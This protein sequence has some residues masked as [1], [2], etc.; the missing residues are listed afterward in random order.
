MSLSLLI[1]LKKSLMKA[2][3]TCDHCD[4]FFCHNSLFMGRVYLFMWI[5]ENIILKFN[6]E[7]KISAVSLVC[8][9]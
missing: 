4:E 2:V 6:V 8:K 1:F 3:T 5:V 7:W 9:M